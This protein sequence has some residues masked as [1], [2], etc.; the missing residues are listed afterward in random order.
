M[1]QTCEL[2]VG[3]AD[4]SEIRRLLSGTD[5]VMYQERRRWIFDRAFTVIAPADVLQ[6]VKQKIQAVLFDRWADRQ[7]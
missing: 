5:K 2:H 7:W 6:A 4:A 1:L 3:W